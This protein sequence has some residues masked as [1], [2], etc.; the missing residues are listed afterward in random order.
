MDQGL[1]Q[2]TRFGFPRPGGRAVRSTEVSPLVEGNPSSSYRGENGGRDGEIEAQQPNNLSSPILPTQDN[3]EAHNVARL[4]FRSWC[5]ACVRGRGLSVGHQKQTEKHEEQVP[6]MSMDYFFL[7]D[8]A[9]PANNLPVLM[10]KD[11]KSG[12]VFS[13]PVPSKGVEHQH[14]STQLLKD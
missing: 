12:A 7:G 3:I 1:Q 2:G 10:V 4:T 11:R 14:G 9:A 5:P 6:T 13:H 8:E